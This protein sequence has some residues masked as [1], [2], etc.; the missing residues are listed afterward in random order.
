MTTVTPNGSMR[1]ATA[2]QRPIATVPSGMAFAPFE[3]DTEFRLDLSDIPRPRGSL[4][5][6]ALKPTLLS[7][8]FDLV[9][10]LKP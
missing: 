4:H 9:A 7:R 2:V 6:E 1:R 5:I 3:D 10:P 8:L